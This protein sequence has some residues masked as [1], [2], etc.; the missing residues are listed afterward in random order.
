MPS[1][2]KPAAERLAADMPVAGEE[3]AAAVR[4]VNPSGLKRQSY[5]NHAVIRSGT[6]V[7]LTGQVSWD[8]NGAVVGA[9]DIDRQV[10]QV[11]R[12]IGLLLAEMGAGPG[13]VVK[14]V[15]YATDRAFLPP[16]HRGRSAFFRGHALP[17][18]TFILVAGL[19]DPELLVEIDVTAVL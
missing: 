18:S 17:A 19:A 5:Y 14:I 4:V 9:G 6:P 10:D 15:T 11:Y 8:E 12:N 13:N 1:A 3:A 2:E 16:L 7:F